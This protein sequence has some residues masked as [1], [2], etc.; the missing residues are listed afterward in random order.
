MIITNKSEFNTDLSR[1]KKDEFT[2]YAP[3]DSF[4]MFRYGQV[5]ELTQEEYNE[6]KNRICLVNNERM[7]NLKK[8]YEERLA[9][10]TTSEKEYIEKNKREFESCLFE[11]PI[12]EIVQ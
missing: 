10:A 1:D 8:V 2:F 11:K 4:K 3:H 6:I 7:G 12:C 9:N 5:A